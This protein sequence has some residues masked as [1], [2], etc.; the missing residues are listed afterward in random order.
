MEE[1]NRKEKVKRKRGRKGERRE[2]RER[3][4]KKNS[5]KRY[6]EIRNLCTYQRT[7]SVEHGHWLVMTLHR[8]DYN[9]K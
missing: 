9:A 5:R 2:G 3:R 8:C 4:G 1:T 6:E 7:V